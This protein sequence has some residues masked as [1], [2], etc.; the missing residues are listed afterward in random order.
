MF[1]HDKLMRETADNHS[2]EVVMGLRV[3]KE[4]VKNAAEYPEH[5]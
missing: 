1:E 3:S 5:Q 4:T 2:A